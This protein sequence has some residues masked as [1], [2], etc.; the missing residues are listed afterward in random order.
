MER[1]NEITDRALNR[2]SP[3]A[4][5]PTVSAS[6]QAAAR[7][8]K[9]LGDGFGMADGSKFAGFSS[10]V[11]AACEAFTVDEIE[12]ATFGL[13]KAKSRPHIGDVYSA[14]ERAREVSAPQTAP[15]NRSTWSDLALIIAWICGNVL[16]WHDWQA[17][18]DN[19]GDDAD[20]PFVPEAKV[21]SFALQN[22]RRLERDLENFIWIAKN[23]GNAEIKAM[24]PFE[25]EM[26]RRLAHA[27]N[28]GDAA[29]IQ[30]RL[31]RLRAA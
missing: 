4:S 23:E 22:Y 16:R 21:E 28:H 17:E 9:R 10:E 15:Q 20:G 3:P 31:D 27:I 1:L 2:P 11:M 13:I 8:L 7:L 26:T 24:K 14:L 30:D 29:A 6:H 19:P 18:F 25:R 5:R 12:R